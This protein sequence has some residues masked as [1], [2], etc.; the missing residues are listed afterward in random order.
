MLSKWLWGGD[1]PSIMGPGAWSW[2]HFTWLTFV[3]IGSALM[4]M[5]ARKHDYKLENLITRIL[6]VTLIV[7]E[8]IKQVV[9]FNFYKYYRF[10][11]FPFYMCSAPIYLSLIS[12]FINN[13]NNKIKKFCDDFNMYFGF[14]GGLSILL[15]PNETIKTPLVFKSLQ[16]MFWHC[17]LVMYSL[18]LYFSRRAYKRH[19]IKNT[20]PAISV[21]AILTLIAV[22]LNE[23]IFYNGFNP[24][25]IPEDRIN[26][27][28]I[29]RHFQCL[30]PIL[31]LIQPKVPYVIFL[32][33]VTASL[34]FIVV[35]L[36]Y[37]GSG[38]Y[39]MYYKQQKKISGRKIVKT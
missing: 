14:F 20:L 1:N 13:P 31:K 27:F 35:L 34:S 19:N 15:S 8:T 21:F 37:I 29:S 38:I 26:C 24:Q 12:S 2:Y 22:A 36:D 9:C 28:L 25:A 7:F 5:L 17:L 32:I 10:E 16:A 18:F 30:Y 39:L 33:I 11:F 3:I 6:C 4:I 23:I